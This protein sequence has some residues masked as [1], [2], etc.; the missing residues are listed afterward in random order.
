M[1]MRF[2]YKVEK[3]LW[4]LD[5]SSLYSVRWIIK[6]C[7]DA[8]APLCASARFVVAEQTETCSKWCFLA[9]EFCFSLRPQTTKHYC[10]AVPASGGQLHLFHVSSHARKLR[11][12]WCLKLTCYVAC[13]AV[14]IFVCLQFCSQV[15]FLIQIPA[16]MCSVLCGLPAIMPH[17]TLRSI[18]LSSLCLTSEWKERDTAELR[19]SLPLSHAA[20]LPVQCTS[21]ICSF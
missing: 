18:C 9:V 11:Y 12:L 5:E 2:I 19:W 17:Y 3:I 8:N 7:Y 4:C 10:A 14:I 20:H 6:D 15:Y 21:V 13:Q 16:P 1:Y